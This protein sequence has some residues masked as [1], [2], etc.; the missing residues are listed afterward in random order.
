MGSGLFAALFGIHSGPEVL[1]TNQ[2]NDK[3]MVIID[4]EA[5][6]KVRPGKSKAFDVERGVHLVELQNSQAETL[7]LRNVR[8]RA[9]GAEVVLDKPSGAVE[10]TNTSGVSLAIKIDGKKV[11][12][13]RD[14]VTE[15]IE[16]PAG[17]HT[18]RALYPYLNGR[19]SLGSSSISVVNNMVTGVDFGPDDNGWV[20]VNNRLGAWTNVK[21]NGKFVQRIERGQKADIRLPLGKVDISFWRNGEKLD[22][23]SFTV[24]PFSENRMHLSKD[25]RNFMMRDGE[26]HFY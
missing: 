3:A 21:V 18:I 22:S 17:E 19:K 26:Y 2:T 6:G 10:I 23:A 13:I 24:E 16:V 4:G 5:V 11:M 7:D 12:D 20:R 1:V 9:D 15:V 25:G 8:V 14:G